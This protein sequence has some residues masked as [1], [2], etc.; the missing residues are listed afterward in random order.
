MIAFSFISEA[1]LLSI[2]VLSALIQIYFWMHRFRLPSDDI[3]TLPKDPKVPISVV[4]CAK[5]ELENLRIT[6][7]SILAQQYPHF[8]LIVCD[9][10]ST[11]NSLDY[12][13]SVENERLKVLSTGKETPGK[14][15]AL[16]MAVNKH[17]YLSNLFNN[18]GFGLNG[19]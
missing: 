8:E 10:N 5:N 18:E 13:N 19:P 17:S 9:D 1:I 7:P 15:Y 12:L 11:D 14:K 3:Q 4:I 2:F 16:E 6:I